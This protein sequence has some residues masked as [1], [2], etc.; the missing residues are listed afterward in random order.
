MPRQARKKFWSGIYHVYLLICKAE[1]IIEAV[2]RCI[3]AAEFQAL[4]REKRDWCL[5]QLKEK[6][7][8]VRHIERLTGINRGVVLKV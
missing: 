2:S 6:G 1:A 8:T 7:L 4:K 3:N 5:E